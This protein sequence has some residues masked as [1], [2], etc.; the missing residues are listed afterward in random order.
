MQN[1]P[2]TAT[3]WSAL[4]EQ[5]VSEAETD[6]FE[7]DVAA[8]VDGA[9]AANLERFVP[10]G[11]RETE[12]I[13]KR[14]TVVVERRSVR[15]AEAAAATEAAAET[16]PSGNLQLLRTPS[17]R[18]KDNNLQ[19]GSI[20]LRTPAPAWVRKRVRPGPG[21]R[22]V[23]VSSMEK[24]L[25]GDG[26]LCSGVTPDTH[27]VKSE[28]H[29]CSAVADMSLPAGTR[30][31][32]T[33]INRA[34]EYLVQHHYNERHERILEK[35]L[36]PIVR[37]FL[38][39]L[40]N[41]FGLGIR[42]L[43]MSRTNDTL[44]KVPLLWV[45][46][47]SPTT[48]GADGTKQ[49]HI[50]AGEADVVGVSQL[51]KGDV[52]ESA[53]EVKVNVVGSGPMAQCAFETLF[54]NGRNCSPPEYHI[55]AIESNSAFLCSGVVTN[56]VVAVGLTPLGY[57]IDDSG[58]GSRDKHG[59][60]QFLF[61]VETS[62]TTTDDGAFHFLAKQMMRSH[63]L[64]KSIE[65]SGTCGPAKAQPFTFGEGSDGGDGE[66]A[67]RGPAPEP[68][69]SPG[70]RSPFPIGRV[71][72]PKPPEKRGGD[73]RRESAI[74]LTPEHGGVADSPGCKSLLAT[75]PSSVR[76]RVRRR[77]PQRDIFGWAAE[78]ELPTNACE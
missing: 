49:L 71:G 60:P 78:V 28:W 46:T 40:S 13:V 23:N 9:T 64:R 77:P 57:D 7:D 68:S 25:F 45:A 4:S 48:Q 34:I 52:F 73:G 29:G 55:D 39:L 37:V 15:L 32:C 18:F 36:E 67:N 17:S 41:A 20:D 1:I 58:K 47:S 50:V 59:D 2:R 62:G 65:Q 66:D 12:I 76:M 14:P 74:E 70:P 33:E 5:T 24:Q 31:L 10:F 61:F 22:P 72:L 54:F 44:L 35:D 6:R 56:G 75:C 69:G 63:A 51:L 30:I 11:Q 19:I 38:Q 27:V 43:S 16:D 53:M 8:D 42:Y 3:D 26:R 21:K